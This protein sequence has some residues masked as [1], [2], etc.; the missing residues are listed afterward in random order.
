MW[1]LHL[2]PIINTANHFWQ[3]CAIVASLK[4]WNYCLV[5]SPFV[6][7]SNLFKSYL[8]YKA[9]TPHA[10][11]GDSSIK[12]FCIHRKFGVWNCSF[13]YSPILRLYS[14]KIWLSKNAFFIL[15]FNGRAFIM[16][17]NNIKLVLE[18]QFDLQNPLKQQKM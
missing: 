16:V 10:V 12:E 5:I 13:H 3:S 15:F 17:K 9:S 8:A 7:T 6:P 1:A 18:F 14:V 11:R 4:G 2:L